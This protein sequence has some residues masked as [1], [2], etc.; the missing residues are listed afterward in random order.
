M[1][2]KYILNSDKIVSKKL[3]LLATSILFFDA[4]QAQV[5]KN[6]STDNWVTNPGIIGTVFLIIIVVI[7]GVF[8]MSAKLNKLASD[9]KQKNI[10]KKKLE[11][12]EELIELDEKEIDEILANRKKALQYQL[13]G[14][15]LGSETEAKDQKGL[16][17][18]VSSD[19][20]NP[21]VDEK[22]SHP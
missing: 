14:D 18:H 7:I 13:S 9:L 19:P 11:F 20:K 6:P 2:K 4:I 16:I 5:E 12:S 22:K 15:E 17:S 3:L 1:E 21:I 10:D 8:I